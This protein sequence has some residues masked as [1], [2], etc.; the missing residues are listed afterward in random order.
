MIKA[1]LDTNVIVSAL[2]VRHGKPAQIVER[3]G[4]KFH[5]LLSAAILAEAYEVLHR[6]R[7]RIKF[8][9]SDEDIFWYL[10]VKLRHNAT[11]V[12]PGSVENVIKNDPPDNLIL[13][14]AVNGHADYL[15][16]GNDH[17]LQL[18]EHRGIKMVSPA[19]FLNVL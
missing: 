8:P 19:E 7:I 17:L 5:L 2:I 9:I 3:A 16:S 18:K 4:V 1:V 13:A 10:E 12:P 11:L 6:E 15:V 14:C